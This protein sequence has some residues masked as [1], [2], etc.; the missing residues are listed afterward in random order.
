[1]ENKSTFK[2]VIENP[3]IHVDYQ[4]AVLGMVRR[5]GGKEGGREGCTFDSMRLVL[6]QKVTALFSSLFFHSPINE[7]SFLH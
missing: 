6:S 2:V 3:A 1:M 7:I 4:G 5:E